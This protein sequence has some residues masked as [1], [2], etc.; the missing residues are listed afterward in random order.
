MANIIVNIANLKQSCE[1]NTQYTQSDG[2]VIDLGKN[3]EVAISLYLGKKKQVSLIKKVKN[4]LT[5]LR[6]EQRNRDILNFQKLGLLKKLME[7]LI[8]IIRL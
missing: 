1:N 6:I 8:L 5:I 4:Y 2:T 7:Q 3:D